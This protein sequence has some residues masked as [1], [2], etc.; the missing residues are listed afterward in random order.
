VRELCVVCPSRL[1]IVGVAVVFDGAVDVSA[2][3]FD[4]KGGAQVHGA[5]YANV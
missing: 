5:V 3:F 4:D 1:A 2:T